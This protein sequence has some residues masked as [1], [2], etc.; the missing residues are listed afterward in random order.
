MSPS[1]RGNASLALVLH[2]QEFCVCVDWVYPVA[3]ITYI[4]T[5][6]LHRA[7]ETLAPV[8]SDVLWRRYSFAAVLLTCWASL[9]RNCTRFIDNTKMLLSLAKS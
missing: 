1:L 6:L 3:K 9:W 4:H 2:Q 5:S 7:M 8:R